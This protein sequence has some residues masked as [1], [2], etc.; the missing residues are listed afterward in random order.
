MEYDRLL[1]SQTF[2]SLFMVFG[3][4]SYNAVV[5][6]MLAKILFGCGGGMPGFKGFGHIVG[7]HFLRLP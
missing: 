4:F 7:A 1:S 6:L 3:P 5:F 2:I